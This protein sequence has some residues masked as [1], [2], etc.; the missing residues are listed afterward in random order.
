VKVAVPEPVA[1]ANKLVPPI[2]SN[3][4]FFAVTFVTFFP[5]ALPETITYKSPSENENVKVGAEANVQHSV[6]AFWFIVHESIVASPDTSPGVVL[7]ASP[8]MLVLVTLPVIG[9]GTPLVLAPVLSIVP[10]P[11]NLMPLVSGSTASS[12]ESSAGESW[13][14]A[15]PSAP[16]F[17]ASPPMRL[18]TKKANA[19]AETRKII[20]RVMVSSPLKSGDFARIFAQSGAFRKRRP[21]RVYRWRGFQ[22]S[23]EIWSSINIAKPSR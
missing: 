16:I 8:C 20:L 22:T 13:A 14:Q 23:R 9:K 5:Q 18:L 1:P 15:R 11:V 17:P 6:L 12:L 4:A 21:T 7:L 3:E 10:F 2:K 19:K